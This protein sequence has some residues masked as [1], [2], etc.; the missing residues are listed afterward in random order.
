MKIHPTPLP[1]GKVVGDEYES[2]FFEMLKN[3]TSPE[4]VEKNCPNCKG[5]K[6]FMKY[7]YNKTWPK[8]L[9]VNVERLVLKD[10]VPKK[11]NC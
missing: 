3:Y 11:S 10:W 6:Q 5:N 7:T 2:D 1:E 4:V 9:I 8:Y